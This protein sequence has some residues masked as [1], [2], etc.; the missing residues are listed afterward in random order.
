MTTDINNFGTIDTFKNGRLKMSQTASEEA[1][2]YKLLYVLGY[3]KT[4][5]N[6]INIYIKREGTSISSV[7]PSDIRQAFFKFLEFDADYSNIPDGIDRVEIINWFYQKRA[8]KENGLYDHYLADTLSVSEVHA[9]SM[10]TDHDYKHDF[11]NNQLLSK[12]DEWNFTKR[13]DTVGAFH[14]GDTLYYKNIGD[15]KYLVFNHFNGQNHN[16]NDCFD[17]W[18]ATYMNESQIGNKKPLDQ[19]GICYGFDLDRDFHLIKDYLN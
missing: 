1:N 2:I 15:K 9:L 18:F 5:L 13:I 12:F 10:L 19:Q 7:H 8:V 16:T 14:K 11:E 17:I 6:N 3:R 4:K